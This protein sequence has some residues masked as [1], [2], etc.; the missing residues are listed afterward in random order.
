MSNPK[1]EF[2]NDLKGLSQ[3]SHE[4]IV[5]VVDIVEA[6]HQRI[7]T[8]GGL[9]NQGDVNKTNGLT[10][11][12]YNTI[13]KSTELGIKGINLALAQFKPSTPHVIN[14]HLRHQWVAILNGILGDHLAATDNPLAT[15]MTLTYQGQPVTPQQAAELCQAQPGN[16]LLLL[17]GLCMN[18]QL[19]RHKLHDHG[20]ELQQTLGFT[21]IHVRYNSGL[22]IHQ[23]G[24]QLAVILNAFFQALPEDN[25]PCHVLCHSMGGLLLR[26]AMSTANQATESQQNKWPTKL[27]KLV[28]LGTPHNGAILEKSGHLLEYIISISTYSAPF[29]KLTGIR[30]QGI[31]D[32]RAGRTHE[33]HQFSPLPDD[34][35]V[36]AI[37]AS[38][39]Q[40]AHAL[41]QK[42]IGDGL[43]SI[44]SALGQH[45]EAEKR[46][47]LSADHQF[48]V[49]GVSHMGLLSDPQVFKHLK[50]IFSD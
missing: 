21:P 14:S 8:L 41:H 43:V 39:Q 5:G 28:F 15:K 45:P 16:P 18:D 22:A 37:A 24:Q 23:N 34:L 1:S 19:W 20:H 38:S 46:L 7:Y 40:Q 27:G 6:M 2:Q 25:K 10:G 48:I 12:I 42:L 3:L 35:D 47:N 13:R 32:L 11:F 26:S 50:Q 49:E 31:K 30:S 44:S 17:H 29:V 9:L 4:G 36:Y 33:N